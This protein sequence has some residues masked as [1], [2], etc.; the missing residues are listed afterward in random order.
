MGRCASAT[1]IGDP[2]ASPSWA[3]WSPSP[4]NTRF[5]PAQQA[6]LTADQVP[7]L[8]LKW[9]FGFP[10]ATSAWSQPTV[11]GGRL[12]VGSQNG[13]VYSL[14]AK[15]GCIYWTFTAKSGVRTA[16]AFG[17]RSDADGYAVYFGDTGANVYALDAATGGVLWSRAMDIHPHARI[18]GSPTLFRGRLFVPVASIEE[19]AAGQQGYQCCTFRGSLNALDATTGDVLWRTFTVPEAQAVGKN[20]AGVTLWGPAGV[21]IWAA[22][23]I[24]EKRNLIYAATG[25]TYSG[26]GPADGRRHRRR[27]SGVRR[28]Q[29]DQADDRAGRLRLPRRRRQLR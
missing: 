27:R 10:D 20:A 19:T 11:A 21:G 13:T 6:G 15:T 22:P 4:T 16:P 7:K 23:T 8:S 2:D 12:F 17:R 24:D 3:G 29:V 5:Q 1:T 14:D 28:H 25:N 26:A 9:A 18:T